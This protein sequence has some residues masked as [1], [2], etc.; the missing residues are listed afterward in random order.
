MKLIFLH[1]SMQ[2]YLFTNISRMITKNTLLQFELIK[3]FLPILVYYTVSSYFTVF[4][5]GFYTNLISADVALEIA[6]NLKGCF[7]RL[8]IPFAGLVKP[9][10]WKREKNYES[11]VA[12]RGNHFALSAAFRMHPRRAACQLYQCHRIFTLFFGLQY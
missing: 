10:R 4:R 3:L 8:A 9:C 5:H 1:N 12:P 7:P 2:N 6:A 11:K